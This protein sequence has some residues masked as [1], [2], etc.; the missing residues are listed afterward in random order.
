MASFQLDF[1]EDEKSV[2]ELVDWHKNS[3]EKKDIVITKS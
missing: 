1:K 2:F 3:N